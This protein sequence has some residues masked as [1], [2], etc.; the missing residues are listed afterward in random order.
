MVLWKEVLM[1]NTDAPNEQTDNHKGSLVMSRNDLRNIMQHLFCKEEYYSKD[2]RYLSNKSQFML[3]TSIISWIL[4][5][6]STGL[7]AGIDFEDDRTCTNVCD[8]FVEK[9]I[10]PNLT[11]PF[12]QLYND[13]YNTT[14]GYH[15]YDELTNNNTNDDDYVTF[16]SDP[17]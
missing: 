5:S 8:D 15:N 16:V 2:D 10:L 1:W 7:L 11:R 12:D 4:K 13:V 9:V 14:D 17:V 3:D 6:Q